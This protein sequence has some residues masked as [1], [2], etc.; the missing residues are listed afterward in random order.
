AALDRPR[1]SASVAIWLGTALGVASHP[2]TLIA[3]ATCTLGLAVAAL[4]A[5]DVPPRRALAAIGHLGIGTAIGAPV[6]MPFAQRL[7]LYGQHFNTAAP[8]WNE[9]GEHLLAA[10]IPITSYTFV[11]YA[12]YLG[13][14]LALWSRRARLVFLAATA[15]ALLVGMSAA[16]YFRLDVVPGLSIARFSP[17]RLA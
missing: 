7:L 10:P 6:W 11:I 9:W 12:G 13:I 5:H 14:A 2:V 1:L 4:P 8:T 17:D 3:V 15:L 16:T